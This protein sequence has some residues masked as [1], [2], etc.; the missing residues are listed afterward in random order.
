MTEEEVLKLLAENRNDRGLCHWE[1][2]GEDTG[3]LASFGIGLT[4]LRKLAKQAGRDHALAGRLWRSDN[5]DVRVLGILIDDPRQVTREQA[6]EQVE[7]VRAGMLAHVFSSCD[8]PLAK[9]S[10]AYDLARDWIASG[11]PLRR[12]C[13]YGL[14]Y[15][16]SKNRRRKELTDDGFLE[17]IERI[18]AEFDEAEVPVRMAMGTALMGIGKRNE[19][20]NRT[21]VELARELGPIDF[22]ENGKKCEPFD[23]VKHLTSESLQAKW[24]S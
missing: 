17:V 16:L 1:T 8:A 19:S 18:R 11:H 21:A 3:G 13:G 7:E 2:M 12:R 6:E 24:K 14:I 20:L 9:T 5:H 15:E 23:V 10:F 22:S 4:Q